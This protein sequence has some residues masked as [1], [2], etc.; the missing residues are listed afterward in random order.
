MFSTCRPEAGQAAANG[1]EEEG[2][3]SHTYDCDPSYSGVNLSRR[4]ISAQFQS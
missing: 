2:S 4:A 1:K 3:P